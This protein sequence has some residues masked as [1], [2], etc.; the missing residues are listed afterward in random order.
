MNKLSIQDLLKSYSIEVTAHQAQRIPR[1]ADDVPPGTRIYIPHTPHTS[2]SEIV[3]LA[4]RIRGEGMEPVPH[5][6]ARRIESMGALQDLLKRFNE[7]AGVT[8]V[9][10]VA[11][12][13]AK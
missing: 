6:V 7:H 11:G 8:Q 12:D 4:G 3:D 10:A 5:V 13:I 2:F 9:L 1:F